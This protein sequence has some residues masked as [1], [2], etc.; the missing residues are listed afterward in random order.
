MSQPWKEAMGWNAWVSNIDLT[1]L[2]IKRRAT[3]Q[4]CS[5]HI[6]DI[7]PLRFALGK[8]PPL[9]D[10]IKT[11]DLTRTLARRKYRDRFTCCVV[12]T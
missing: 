11:I 4:P 10:S 5:A 2:T 3:G 8:R 9:Q 12:H 6:D 1:P 7:E